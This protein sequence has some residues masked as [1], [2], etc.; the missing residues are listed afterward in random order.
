MTSFPLRQLY[1]PYLPSSS[2]T[3]SYFILTYVSS[4]FPIAILNGTSFFTTEQLQ[5][6]HV[7]SAAK[8]YIW[9][10]TS[11]PEPLNYT[12]LNYNQVYTTI[13]QSLNATNSSFAACSC[14]SQSLLRLRSKPI[15]PIASACCQLRHG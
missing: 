3:L 15:T 7:Y 10:S 11:K 9:L 6:H 12:K 1:F 13:F 5:V 2:V 8:T 14:N 4:S